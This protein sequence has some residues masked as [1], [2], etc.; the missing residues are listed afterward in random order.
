MRK[1]ETQAVL[2]DT[3]TLHFEGDSVEE[4]EEDIRTKCLFAERCGLDPM[5][6]MRDEAGAKSTYNLTKELRKALKD[7]GFHLFT[8]PETD[9]YRKLYDAEKHKFKPDA[10]V[11]PEEGAHAV[12]SPRPEDK[13]KAAPTKAEEGTVHLSSDMTE[14]EFADAAKKGSV[15]TIDLEDF[16]NMEAFIAEAKKPKTGKEGGTK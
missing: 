4:Y 16:D 6:M 13:V 10:P 5:K 15:V 3:V 2:S 12:Y 11:F 1:F 9:L 8:T 14:E 7:P